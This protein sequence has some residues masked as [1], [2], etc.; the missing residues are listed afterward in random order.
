MLSRLMLLEVREMLER[1]W[2]VYDIA[3]K[4]HVD[5]AVIAAAVQQ[6]QG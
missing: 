3:H 1:H 2:S 5:P 6:L 4:M